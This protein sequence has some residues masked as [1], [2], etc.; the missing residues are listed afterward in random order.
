MVDRLKQYIA[1]AQDKTTEEKHSIAII[2]AGSVSGVL[3]VIW[4]IFAL[5]YLRTSELPAHATVD[6][7]PGDITTEDIGEITTVPV[8]ENSEPADPTYVDMQTV[9]SIYNPDSQG[10]AQ[11]STTEDTTPQGSDSAPSVIE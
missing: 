8:G 6:A 11:T 1:T 2:V 9:P 3:L 5:Y 10:R 4:L 7:T